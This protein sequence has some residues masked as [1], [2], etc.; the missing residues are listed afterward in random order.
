[1]KAAKISIIHRRTEAGFNL[2]E[3][4]VGVLVIAIS[5]LALYEMFIQG[6]RMLREESHRNAALEKAV[7]RMETMKAYRLSCDTVPRMLSGRFEEYIVPE[8]G[9]EEPLAADVY[10]DVTHSSSRQQNGMP[11]NSIVIVEYK[12][13]EPETNREQKIEFHAKY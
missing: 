8:G 9:D 3:L 2:I 7:G 6:T 13:R 10:V 4:M 5:T 12:W 1:M 11:N